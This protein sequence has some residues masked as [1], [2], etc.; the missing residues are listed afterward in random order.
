M[1]HTQNIIN[2]QSIKENIN[3]YNNLKVCNTPLYYT[4]YN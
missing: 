4:K 1:Y 3:V 2:P